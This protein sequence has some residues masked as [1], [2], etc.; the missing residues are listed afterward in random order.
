VLVGR[1]EAL[2]RLDWVVSGARSGRGGALLLSGEP[3]A[4]KTALLEAVATMATDATHP[5]TVLRCHGAEDERELPYA[6]LHALLRR[7]DST[8]ATLLPAQRAALDQALGRAEGGRPAALTVAAATLSVIDAI[9]TEGPL[10]VLVDD[11]QW[12][13]SE[14]REALAFMARR[15]GDSAV[16]VVMASRSDGPALGA[17]EVLAVPDLDG[18]AALELLARD[19]VAVAVAQRLTESVGGN[20]L[21]LLEIAAH[22]DDSQRSGAAPL[23][24]PLPRTGAGAAFAR[25]IA[26][27]APDARH[28]AGIAAVAGSVSPQTLVDALE[29]AG[30]HWADLEAA[31]ATGLFHL[32]AGQVVWRHPLAQSAARDALT[33]P[34]RR[35]AHSAVA[36]ALGDADGD[37]ATVAWHRVDASTGPDADVA[38]A[39]AD[40]AATA[41]DRGAHRAAGRAY[42][43]AARLS[44][45]GER[46][47][48]YVGR[49]GLEAWLGD[50]AANAQRLL[51]EALPG[52]TDP[53][54][55]WELAWTAGQVSGALGSPRDTYDAFA[56]ARAVARAQGRADREVQALASSFNSCLDLGEPPLVDSLV[57]SIVGIADADDPVQAFR[58]HAVQGF[59]FLA[60]DETGPGR[61]HLDVALGLVEDHDL[62]DTVPLLLQPT[63][64]A[65]MWSGQTGRLRPQIERTVARF[66]AD[67][68][69]RL[70]IAAVRGLAWCD[71]AGAQWDSSALLADEAL[72]LARLGARATDVCDGLTQVAALEGVRGHTEDAVRHAREAQALSRSLA[73]SYRINDALWCEVLAQISAMDLG[74]LAE[75]ADAMAA[76]LLSQ[77]TLAVQ[78]EYFDA[79]LALALLERPEQARVLRDRLLEGLGADLRPESRVG[80]QLCDAHLEADSPGLA[81]ATMRLAESLV[82]DEYVFGRGRLRL[83][84]GAMTR[85]LGQRV[86]ARALLRAAE[87]DFSRLGATPWLTRTQDELRSSGATLRS[88]AEADAALTA[89]EARVARA[90]ASGLS[91]KEIAAALFLSPKTVEFHLGRIFRKLGVRTRAELVR[92]V[93][94]GPYAPA[95]RTTD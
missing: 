86:E 74:G 84:A 23:P 34:Q 66:K 11:L 15:V 80:L 37:P 30:S 16:A 76:H 26:S 71:Y 77:S 32:S 18:D 45:T 43:A 72:E 93:L 62:L 41:S 46:A 47:A 64:Q 82:D 14:S 81:E 92:V 21:A 31:E 53:D 35:A 40:V 63:V 19:G 73:S 28:A 58:S 13:D 29:R 24:D 78:P 94:E 55:R 17:V 51:A 89:A 4:G 95:G 6:G 25:S 3:G 56:V 52:V 2:A 79:P 5:M 70:L 33:P 39:V 8:I 10:L 38:T 65:V 50:D 85:R 68:D 7:A 83:A 67:G 61:E 87:V 36:D 20:P 1:A 88:S 44:P 91:T 59:A 60:A 75:P 69:T 22:L 48:T 9:A 49:A 90:A 12:L 57:E 27:V 42:E 54:L